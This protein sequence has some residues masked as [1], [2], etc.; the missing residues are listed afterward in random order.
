MAKPH[1]AEMARLAETFAWACDV[2]IEAL[3]RAARTAG[4]MPLRAVGSGGSLTAAHALA[5][6]HQNDSSRYGT[7][8]MHE[9]P[10]LGGRVVWR[11]VKRPSTQLPAPRADW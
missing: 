11:G 6:P 9:C 7:P 2:E 4:G 3:R 10:G 8:S 1:A 5:Q